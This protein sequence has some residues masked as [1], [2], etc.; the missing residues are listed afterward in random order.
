MS[1]RVGP[2]AANKVKNN[3]LAAV[4]VFTIIPPVLAMSQAVIEHSCFLISQKLLEP[5]EISLTAAHCSK[6]LITAAS[7]GHALLQQCVRLLIPGIITYITTVAALADEPDAQKMHVAAIEEI[8]KAFSSLVPSIPAA[9]RSGV[10]G[11]FIPTLVLLLD[12]FKSPSS[13]IHVQVVTHLLSFATGSP[14]AFKEITGKL[15][16]TLCDILEA[17][18]RQALGETKTQQPIV[19]KPQISLRSF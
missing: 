8:L 6:I 16:Q 19:T 12:P 1:G 4:L 5:P 9:L 13:P 10:L 18:I 3:M 15:D 14:T 7:T 11:I 2:S 17:S